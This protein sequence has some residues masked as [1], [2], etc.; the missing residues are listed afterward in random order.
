MNPLDI[1]FFT[2]IPSP[3]QIDLGNAFVNQTNGRFSMVCWEPIHS[4]RT[5]LGWTDYEDNEWLIKA[6]ASKFNYSK[7][8]DLIMGA[9]IVIWAYAPLSI[10]KKRVDAGKLTFLYIE[11]PFKRGR[12]RI[13]DPRVARSLF[14]NL[15]FS[16]KENYH[17]LSVG[18]YCAE[19]YKFLGSFKNRMWRWGYFPNIQDNPLPKK[20]NTIP[21]ILWAGRMVDWKRVDLLLNAASWARQ[22]GCSPFY[23]R[24]IGGGPEEDRLKGLA[25]SLQLLD[26]CTFEK[27]MSPQ[28]IGQAME[29]AEYYV[30]PSDKNEGW[31]V[32]VNEAMAHGC[33]LI[34]AKQ[35]GAVPWLIQNGVNGYIFESKCPQYLGELIKICVNNPSLSQSIGIAGQSS[36]RLWSPKTA[37]ERLVNLSMALSEKKP[38][39]Y[40]DNGPCSPL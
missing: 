8:I 32:V 28:E 20:W 34:A 30:L 3:Y 17:L 26:I 27:P 36:I 23:L 11:R 9:D 2:N 21:T 5:K 18:P 14:L 39:L 25:A 24:I 10:I 16:F 29:E 15:H 6:W 35:A 22:N 19:D 7:A 40:S 38:S 33:C 1:T 13:F 4:E 37:A 12:W 31:G